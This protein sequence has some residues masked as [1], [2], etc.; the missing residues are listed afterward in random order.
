MCCS[1]LCHVAGCCQDNAWKGANKFLHLYRDRPE[2]NMAQKSEAKLRHDWVSILL[3]QI[4]RTLPVSLTVLEIMIIFTTFIKKSSFVVP[5]AV[6][7][8]L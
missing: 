4:L 7:T 1:S 2:A 8:S 6:N 3:I 5:V